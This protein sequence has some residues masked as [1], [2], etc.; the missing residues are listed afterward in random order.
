MHVSRGRRAATGGTTETMWLDQSCANLSGLPDFKAEGLPLSLVYVWTEGMIDYQ[1]L[2]GKPRLEN[3]IFKTCALGLPKIQAP[4][5]FLKI[6]PCQRLYGWYIIK[7]CALSA[8]GAYVHA[9]HMQL[10]IP[11]AATS[12]LPPL[13]R[14][15]SRWCIYP[16]YAQ[17]TAASAIKL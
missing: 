10:S 1:D 16:A 3:N 6:W 14:A 15:K 7:T 17:L 13:S 5:A 9:E 8:C 12:P 4:L 11:A 2:N